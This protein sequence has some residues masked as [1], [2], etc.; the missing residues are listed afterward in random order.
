M[1]RLVWSVVLAGLV[2]GTV[3]ALA[4]KVFGI[5]TMGAILA[6]PLAVLVG[7]VVALLAGKPFWTKDARIECGLKA[8]FG[9]LLAAG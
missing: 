4:V 3:A 2:G 6:Y 5:A 9:A 8:G 1:L 7:V